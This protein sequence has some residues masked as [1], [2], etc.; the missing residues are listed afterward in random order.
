VNLFRTTI[1]ISFS[2]LSSI[3]LVAQKQFTKGLILSQTDSSIIS[4]AHIINTT[5]KNGVISNQTGSFFIQAK[6]ED[7]L[8]ISF[9]GFEALKIQVSEAEHKIYL[10]RAIYNIRP[11]T[12]LPY[13][14]FKEFREAFTKLEIKDTLKDIVNPSIML[15]I[16][17]LKSYIPRGMRKS[18]AYGNPGKEAYLKMLKKD[19]LRTIRFN[20]IVIKKIT[21]IKTENQIKTFIEYCDFTDH[22]ID[23]STE[24]R[25]VD[26]IIYCY[27]EYINLP[28]AS[29]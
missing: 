12:V 28:M 23:S 5:S 19:N 4:H 7:T 17:E 10:K 14:D 2:A 1:L 18:G 24:Y 15:S 9:I 26:Q 22:F 16:A 25:L 21:Q 11:F 8:L 13:K 27:K 20:P 29:K 6:L 3:S